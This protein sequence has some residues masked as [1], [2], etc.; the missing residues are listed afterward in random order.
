MNSVNPFKAN[1][2]RPGFA[3]AAPAA[4]LPRPLP[5]APKPHAGSNEP[6]DTADILGFE[7]VWPLMEHTWKHGKINGTTTH[8]PALD[9]HFTWKPGELT[10]VTGWPGSGKSEFL[11]QLLNA[12]AI[13]DGWKW[14]LFCPENMPVDELV[15]KLVQS[16]V[17]KTSNQKYPQYRMTFTEYKEATMFVMNHFSIIYPKGTWTLGNLLNHLDWVMAQREIK[18]FL[19]DP[20]NAL[21]S[22]LSAHG[23]REDKWLEQTL[24]DFIRYTEDRNLHNI[25]IAHPSGQARDKDGNLQVPDQ[26]NVSGGRMWNNKLDNI[27]AVHRPGYGKTLEPGEK[28][29]TS[30]EIHVHKIKK[31]D[32][33]GIPGVATLDYERGNFRYIDP[34]LGYA[35]LDRQRKL[36]DAAPKVIQGSL[37]ASTFEDE[38]A[39]PLPQL[40]P[41]F[42]TEDPPF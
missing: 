42:A 37:P 16:Y 28:P 19:I 34:S 24:T 9:P 7:E 11:L 18:G 3:P 40:D 13:Y 25:I 20:W 4:P 23:G 1:Q 6:I 36:R 17:G 8:F 35:P 27:M 33:V 5:I 21:T 12:K 14:A 26:Y 29:D 15:D 31:Q 2:Q 32:L 30:V 38:P 39:R 22:D 10:L 41:R